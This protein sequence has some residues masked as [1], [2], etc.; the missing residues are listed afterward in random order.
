MTIEP[1]ELGYQYYPQKGSTLFFEL[2]RDTIQKL[3]STW[4]AVRSVPDL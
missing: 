1:P 2:V 3:K 4:L